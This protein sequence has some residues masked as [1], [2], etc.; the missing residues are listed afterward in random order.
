MR[1]IRSISDDEDDS[2]NQES[3]EKNSSDSEGKEKMTWDETYDR[4]ND[5]F[6]SG[7][8]KSTVLTI[9]YI[10]KDLL[11]SNP[12]K[13]PTKKEFYSRKEEIEAINETFVECINDMKWNRIRG[14]TKSVTWRKHKDNHQKNNLEKFNNFESLAEVYF[15]MRTQK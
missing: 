9:L 1:K 6:I 3:H 10:V 15:E 11:T 2:G 7:L 4:N 12:L 5:W 8:P 14:V 13:E